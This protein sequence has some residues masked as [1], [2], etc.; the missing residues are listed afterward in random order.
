LPL[1][2]TRRSVVLRI[3][4]DDPHERARALDALAAVY[5]RPVLRHVRAR[6]RVPEPEGEDL[7]Q[8]FFAAAL[9]KGWLE[10]FDPGRGRFRS[11]LLACLDGHVANERRA[12]AALKRGGG[13]SFV[14]LEPPGD[15][16]MPRERPVADGTDLD[17]A[18]QREWARSVFTVALGALAARCA[19]TSRETALAVFRRCDV[20]GAE[21][22]ERPSY[23]ALAREFGLS[24]SQV[25]NHLHWARREL[26][27]EVLE[28]LRETT[29]SEDEFRTEARALLGV[30]AP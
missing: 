20:E 15:D 26:R 29:A 10:R 22:D 8:S 18:F 1:P 16:G 25:T 3:R 17:A 21:A 30:E 7:V 19:G 6:F 12:A 23:A 2:D 28:T 5:W 9:E 27:R 14:P 11:Y 13:V 4:S 24:V